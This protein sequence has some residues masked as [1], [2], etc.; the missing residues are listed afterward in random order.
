MVY[1]TKTY[2]AA[3]WDGDKDAVEQLKKWNHSNYWWISFND[4]HDLQQ[5]RD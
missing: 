5:A 2:I 4:A 1:R 3:E